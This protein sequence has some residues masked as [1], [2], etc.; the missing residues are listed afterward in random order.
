MNPYP[1]CLLTREWQYAAFATGPLLDFWRQRQEGMFIGVDDVP[2]R[3]V[4]FSSLSHSHLV[5][6]LPGRTDSYV[7]YAEAAYDLFQCGYDVLMMDHRGQGRSGRLLKD[8]HRGHVRRFCDYVDDVAT[9]W[10]QQVAPGQ[11][12][13]RF[14]LAHSM[15]GAILAQFLARQPQTF[16]AVALCAPMCGILLPMP[17]WLAWRI[18]DW[19]ERYPAIRDYYAIGTSQWRPLPFMV[20]VLTHSHA[21]YRRHVRFYADDPDLRIGGPTYH[22]VREALQVETQLLQQAPAI[23]TPLLLLQAEEERVVDNGC[24]DAFCQ[25]LATAHPCADGH[26]YVIRGARHDI[27]SEKDAMRAE[28]FGRILRHFNDYH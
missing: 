15:G 8:S 2:I 4:R 14:A 1:E 18:L 20:N 9:L 7:K 11:Y 28:A 17:R 23:T 13:K 12:T 27:L 22:W 16:D 25:A 21:R 26:P 5:V 3:F 24:Q 10:Q 19:A 6:V